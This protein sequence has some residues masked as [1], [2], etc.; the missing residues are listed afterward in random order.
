MSLPTVV[1]VHQRLG[2]VS[3][4]DSCFERVEVSLRVR[5]VVEVENLALVFGVS[6]F[7]AHS[8]PRGLHKLGVTLC[9]SQ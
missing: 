7:D 4:L 5:D 3:L 8:A 1:V 2:N 6:D 9:V